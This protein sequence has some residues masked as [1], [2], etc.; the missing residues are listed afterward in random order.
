M[1]L[2]PISHSMLVG[3]MKLFACVKHSMVQVACWV[4]SMANAYLETT[5]WPDAKSA[6]NHIYLLDGDKMLAYIKQGGTDEFWFKKPIR[7]DRRARKFDAVEPSPFSGLG[8]RVVNTRTVVGSKGQTY[9][10]NLDENTCTCAGFTF[11]GECKHTK[12]LA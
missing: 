2:L 12:A 10:V 11:R 3:L 1:I 5:I 9:I 8:G 4:L 6:V 7:I